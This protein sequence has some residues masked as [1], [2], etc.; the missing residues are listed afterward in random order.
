MESLTEIGLGEDSFDCTPTTEEMDGDYQADV[1]NMRSEVN[2]LIRA[3][4]SGKD[5]IARLAKYLLNRE[6]RTS[7]VDTQEDL[8]Q[9]YRNMSDYPSTMVEYIGQGSFGAV[10]KVKWLG[11]ICAKKHFG[12]DL[13][14]Y[15]DDENVDEIAIMKEFMKEVGVLV[16]SN[17]SHILELLCL[18]FKPY[19]FV[20]E[21]MPMD[22]G[23]FISKQ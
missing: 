11:M 2:S 4:S 19:Y 21:I 8:L 23:K 9:F 22:L 5:D 17:N 10:H 14:I 7:S 3:H 13:S 15:D 6:E 20:T 16:R 1:E 12:G 18:S